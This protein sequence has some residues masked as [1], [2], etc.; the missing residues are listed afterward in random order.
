VQNFQEWWH[1]AEKMVP[2][3]MRDGLNSLISLVLWYLWKH[4]NACVFDKISPLVPRIILDII[5][6]AA[7]WC[8]AG[9]K[10]LVSLGLGRVTIG[11]GE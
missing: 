8:R 9:A 7:L 11:G 2:K 5:S 4:R 10:G 1:A 6:E 3:Q